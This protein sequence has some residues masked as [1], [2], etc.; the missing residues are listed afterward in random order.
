MWTPRS[1]EHDKADSMVN[2]DEI[3]K[4]LFTHQ[5]STVSIS[6]VLGAQDTMHVSYS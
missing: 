5:Y 4:V 3:S 2:A 6:N 1:V